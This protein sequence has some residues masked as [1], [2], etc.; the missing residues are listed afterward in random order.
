MTDD[1]TYLDSQFA[2]YRNEL[3]TDVTPAGPGA[4]RATVRHRR[5][6]AATTGAVVAAVL[7]VGPAAGYAA[8]SRG[9]APPN[10]GTTTAPTPS[11]SPTPS[12]TP[13]PSPSASPSSTTAPENR[14]S[15]TELLRTKVTLVDWGDA[16]CEVTGRLGGAEPQESGLWL[17]DLDHADVDRNGTTE[18]VATVGCKSGPDYRGRQ[19]AV[20][21]R[22]AAGKIVT[23]GQV[24]SDRPPSLNILQVDTRAD[25][26][27]RVQ[28]SDFRTAGSAPNTENLAQ[29]QWRT[30]A[31]D[32]SGF[33][34][35]GGPTSFPANPKLADLRVTATDAVFSGM[36][37]SATTTVTI[38]NAGPADARYVF[39][40]FEF[41]E[42]P[43]TREGTGWSRCLE[44]GD[45]SDN[46]RSHAI[47][48][49]LDRVPAGETV[50]LNLG[51]FRDGLIP[52]PPDAHL[53]MTRLDEQ[54]DPLP[55][56]KDEDNSTTF[57]IR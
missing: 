27:V 55:D 10:P 36:R 19:V 51:L 37:G 39:L 30:Y 31:W 12:T 42:S 33:D 15:R 32:G 9:P 4:V 50:T 20:F 7:I 23:K 28:V 34:Q 45:R 41:Y 56:R 22:T 21:E 13:P 2:A 48:C 1:N 54:R 8:L 47:T 57:A 38:R 44:S 5:R 35:T 6:V 14:I 16:P 52:E 24:L 11:T 43:V 17:E 40:E 18:A 3:I 25:G 29:K 49:L 53:Q 26:S 46:D